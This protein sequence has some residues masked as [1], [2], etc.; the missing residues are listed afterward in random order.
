MYHWDCLLPCRV[1]PTI[2]IY[3]R[4]EYLLLMPRQCAQSAVILCFISR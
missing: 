4:A 2:H 3:F 1:T